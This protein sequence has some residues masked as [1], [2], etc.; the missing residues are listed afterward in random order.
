MTINA[1][2]NQSFTA[3][4]VKVQNFGPQL[5]FQITTSGTSQ[6]TTFS[7]VTGTLSNTF[8]FCNKGTTNGAY[9]AWGKSGST[10]A[11]ASTGT[12]TANCFYIG[13]GEDL[14]LDLQITTGIVD[15]IAVIQDGGATT[16]EISSGFGS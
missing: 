2:K 13:P 15:T 1:Y 7:A 12:P 11:A 3:A 10:T 6:P 5:S 16:L 4:P 8:R 9:I 14:V